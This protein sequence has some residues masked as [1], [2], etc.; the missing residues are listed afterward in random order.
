[1]TGD[2]IFRILAIVALPL[3]FVVMWVLVAFFALGAI[4]NFSSH[5]KI[6]RLWGPVASI[7]AVCCLLIAL[8]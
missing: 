3:S 4:A 6:E 1:M 8:G 7:I 5:S 2:Q